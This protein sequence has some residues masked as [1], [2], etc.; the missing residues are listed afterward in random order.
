VP[1]IPKHYIIVESFDMFCRQQTITSCSSHG[2]IRRSKTLLS[3]AT[4][5]NS[6]ISRF[7]YFLFVNSGITV[8]FAVYNVCCSSQLSLPKAN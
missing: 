2:P 3:S 7:V 4:C 8:M 1:D 5:L 6:S